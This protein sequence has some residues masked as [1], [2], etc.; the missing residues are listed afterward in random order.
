MLLTFGGVVSAFPPNYGRIYDAIDRLKTLGVMPLWVGATRP[1]TTTQLRTAVEE[2]TRRAQ[3]RDLAYSDTLLLEELQQAAG[4]TA[5]SLDS[6]PTHF[7]ITRPTVS[8]SGLTGTSEWIAGAAGHSAVNAAGI[9]LQW[10]GAA[11]FLGRALLSWGPNGSGGLLFSD[12]AGGFDRAEIS[13]SWGRS[14]FTKFVGIL[15]QNRSIIGTRLDIMY[16]P[17]I[18]IGISESI[19]MPGSPYWLYAVTPMPLLLNEYIEQRLRS[20]TVDVDNQ[21]NLAEL[22]WVLKPGVRLFGEL[23][24]DDFTVPTPTANFPHRAG[25]SG[26]LHFALPRNDLWLRYTAV[27]NWTY[28]GGTSPSYLLRS[29]PLAHPLGAD[30]DALE[31]RWKP[32]Q[33]SISLWMT[34]IRKGEGKIGRLWIDETEANQSVFLSGI[35]ETSWVLG[36]D[37]AFTSNAGW[38]GTVGPWIAYRSNADHTAGVIRVDW[39]LTLAASR[40]F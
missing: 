11:I 10:Q 4:V 3:T 9:A 34:L 30:F 28:T 35:V 36:T 15:D 20:Q 7:A 18:R 29:L 27:T 5:V 40:S 39:G 25:I 22:E 17:H 6:G 24:I 31:T 33:G 2:A 13:L 1:I 14:R 21:F 37:V 8:M 19:I 23:L 26:G 16:R 38:S 32:I 12:S